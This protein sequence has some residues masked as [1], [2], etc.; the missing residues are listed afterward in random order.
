MGFG[1]L[2]YAMLLQLRD[3]FSHYRHSGAKETS[4]SPGKF[5]SS[6]DCTFVRIGFG[7]ASLKLMDI[8]GKWLRLESPLPYGI[9]YAHRF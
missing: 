6:V 3:H 5:F 1:C 2:H 7:G 4:P 9:L 8:S